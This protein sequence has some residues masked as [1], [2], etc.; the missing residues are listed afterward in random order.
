M[1][2]VR[3]SVVALLA[4]VALVALPKLVAAQESI[5]GQAIGIRIIPNP[6]RLAPLAWYRGNVPNP[7][8]P[9]PLEVDGYPAV[10]DG[11]T[12]YV[13]GT[14]Y[15]AN[16]RS[17]YA[18]I[19]LISYSETGDERV[20]AVFEEFLSQFRLNSNISDTEIKQQLRRDMHR[21]ADISTMQTY[22]GDYRTKTGKYPVFEAGSY[23]PNTSYSVWPSWQSTLGNL[24]GVALPNDPRNEFIGCK[25]PYD[26]KTCWSVD[27]REFA[28]PSEAYAYGYRGAADGLSYNLFT[29][30]EYTGPGNWQ[31]A[32]VSQQSAGQCF[33]FSAIDAADADNDG[34]PAVID[35]CPVM[36][37]AGQQDADGDKKG[38]TCDA[39]PSDP[40]N[41]QD[42]DGVCGNVDSCPTLSNPDQTD[43]D[44]DGVG[45][46]CDY[47]TCGNNITEGTESCDGQSAVNQFQECAADCKS[48]RSQAFCGDKIIQ[49]PNE[50][51]INEECDGIDETQLCSTFLNGYK[52]Q[53]VR[54]C[55]NTCR[56]APWTECQPLEKCGDGVVNGLETCDV[57]EQNGVQCQA[58]YGQTCSY[59]SKVCKTQVALGPRCGD[60]VI[61]TDKGEECDEGT[62]NGQRC[63]PAYGK[64]CN[65][66]N[67]SCKFDVVRGPFCGDGA[68]NVP[69]EDCDN[70]SQDVACEQEPTYFYKR[71]NCVQTATPQYKICTWGPYEACRQ[72]GS[73]GDGT[74]NGPEKCDDT[75][76]PG[77]CSSCQPANNTATISYTVTSSGSHT[78]CLGNKSDWNDGISCPDNK[79]GT[80]TIQYG[81]WSW[82]VNKF[83]LPIPMIVS[84]TT[85]F[86]QG[87]QGVVRTLQFNGQ[88]TF[89][90]GWWHGGNHCSNGSDQYTE[91]TTI[92]NALADTVLNTPDSGGTI[93]GQ[94]Q[95]TGEK[96][97]TT[98]QGIVELGNLLSMRWQGGTGLP[99]DTYNLTSTN[100]T[101]MIWFGNSLKTDPNSGSTSTGNTST[102]ILGCVDVNNNRQCDFLEL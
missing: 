36:S 3:L 95:F 5:R 76:S 65:F 75:R 80:S 100:G 88:Q 83:D 82:S 77:L 40:T 90:Q 97:I 59:C 78:F 102:Y 49:T 45:D 99:A 81:G 101:F 93:T 10:R 12:V 6:K 79:S 24:L 71:R 60:S 70:Q 68:R 86:F 96:T 29:S 9:Q 20:Q 61:Q 13:A 47:Q 22:L 23:L 33:N 26:T 67:N 27:K 84:T 38:D 62:K 1:K 30:F 89:S 94:L 28:C 8:N 15:D 42:N 31:T 66:C 92:P 19:Y 51:G 48:I 34:V 69:F 50:Q 46:V 16:T 98:T 14:N 58:A 43:L 72:V 74:V 35:N 64:S 53:R 63:V 32:S 56:Y 55:R 7:G 39:C 25:A 11:R 21:A 57:K 87:C 17:L 52:T 37:N 73:C 18:N 4:V 54:A 44:L 41:D 85:S 2:L 91:T